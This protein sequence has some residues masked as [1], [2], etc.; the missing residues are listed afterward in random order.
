MIRNLSR[1]SVL[2][3]VLA[4]T[5]V[6]VAKDGM[7]ESRQFAKSK[8]F[9]GRSIPSLAYDLIDLA[10]PPE[11]QGKKSASLLGW[12]YKDGIEKAGNE[13]D[14]QPVK[15]L[16]AANLHIELLYKDGYRVGVIRKFLP[17]RSWQ[18]TD[19]FHHSRHERMTEV[20][21]LRGHKIPPAHLLVGVMRQGDARMQPVP[22]R[23]TPKEQA[24]Y[25]KDN[26]GKRSPR[27]C[28]GDLQRARIAALLNLKTGKLT[29]YSIK[30]VTCVSPFFDPCTPD[31]VGEYPTDINRF[32]LKSN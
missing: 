28:I 24:Q 11:I 25:R 15:T 30:P 20:C 13:F 17:D 21:D 26:F 23:P 29:N 5:Q 10:R 19:V 3:V 22:K 7:D 9:A 27:M 2:V 32:P 1:Y 31:G 4:W 8:D 6:C 16:L 14:D 18:I 12:I